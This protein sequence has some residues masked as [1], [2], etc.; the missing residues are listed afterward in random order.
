MKAPQICS[1]K[2]VVCPSVETV[3]GMP[4]VAN[5]VALSCGRFACLQC[6]MEGRLPPS[7]E[8]AIPSVPRM[9]DHPHPAAPGYRCDRSDYS[10]S[11]FK[12]VFTTG[13]VILKAPYPVKVE[14]GERGG[15]RG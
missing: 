9:F 11:H 6:G 13:R 3:E 10:N 14:G 15:E 2:W 12:G 8:K 1:V 5:T 4:H 7:T